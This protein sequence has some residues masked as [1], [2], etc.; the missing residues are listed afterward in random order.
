MSTPRS[1]KV[2]VSLLRG[3]NVGGNNKVKMADLRESYRSLGFGDVQSYIQSGNVVFRADSDANAR[4]IETAIER[5]ITGDYG[6]TVSVMA[7]SAQ[8]LQGVM[9]ASPFDT[10]DD[11][12]TVIV[13]LSGEGSRGWAERARDHLEGEECLA[14]TDVAAY[15]HAANGLGRSKAASLL[16]SPPPKGI[17]ATMR[18]MRTLNSLL[19]MASGEV[20]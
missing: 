6:F 1:I 2:F 13:F 14:T 4:V 18:N 16:L 5:R 8:E 12:K 19:T 11:A 7:M 3:I 15:F 20:R 9:D 10:A 17:K